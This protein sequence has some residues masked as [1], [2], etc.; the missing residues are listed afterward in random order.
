MKARFSNGLDTM[1][2]FWLLN[3]AAKSGGAPA[4][5]ID[6]VE[7]IANPGFSNYVS[8]TLH[9]WSNNTTPAMSH[10]IVS[11]PTT[12]FHTYGMLWTATT[13]TFY[14]DGTVTF[15]APTPSIMQQPYYLLIDQGL[16]G[17]WP[18]NSTPPVNDM[19]IQ[20]IRVYSN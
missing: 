13:M 6:I 9:N 4:G 5:E 17:G 2:A 16:G 3:T 12:G 10:N 19:L 1:P 18:T 8:T 15:Q 11:T 7:Y 20:Y 14:F